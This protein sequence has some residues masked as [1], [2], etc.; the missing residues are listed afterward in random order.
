MWWEEKC[1]LRA[2]Y[3]SRGSSFDIVEK[4]EILFNSNRRKIIRHFVDQ[5]TVLECYGLFTW[6]T[7]VH[8]FHSESL[9]V[10][11]YFILHYSR[12][13]LDE[14]NMKEERLKQYNF[15]VCTSQNRSWNILCSSTGIKSCSG[16]FK[17]CFLW[18]IS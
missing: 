10:K 2:F 9:I 15:N 17:Q 6:V 3:F 11:C 18:N 1:F 7:S 12:W 13:T 4:A 8:L 14:R 16:I 5:S